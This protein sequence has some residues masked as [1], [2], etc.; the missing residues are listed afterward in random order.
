MGDRQDGYLPIEDYAVIG[1]GRTAALVGID[2]AVD[3]LCLPNLDSPAVF[4]A[5]LDARR[6]GSFVVQ[7]SVAF[8]AERRYLPGLDA[9]SWLSTKHG[10]SA[11]PRRG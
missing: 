5:L 8:E 1:D 11:P 4:A 7:P 9:S 6:G 3:W 10:R 2:G